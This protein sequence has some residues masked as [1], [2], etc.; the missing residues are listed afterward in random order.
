MASINDNSTGAPGRIRKP[1]DFWLGLLF[2]LFAIFAFSLAVEV[3][4]GTAHRMGA[5]YF[6]VM[7]SLL[8]TGF[9]VILVV[10][11]FFGDVVEMQGFRPR[12]PALV[13]GGVVLFAYLIRN[14][15]LIVAVCA[16]VSV[17]AYAEPSLR[18]WRV[19]ALAA[20]LAAG[21]YL[22]FVVALGQPLPL[23]GTWFG[24]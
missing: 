22:I 24:G 8:L 11:S 4:L 6:P 23:V 20:T 5:G 2:V 19:A 3:P 14:G 13:L 21:S 17:A 7:L 18:G 10:R 1:K 15:G 12:A 16:M 9:G